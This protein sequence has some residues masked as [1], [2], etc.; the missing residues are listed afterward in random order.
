MNT[1]TKSR[2][3]LM[4]LMAM[5]L[6]LSCWLVVPS[7]VQEVGRR[8]QNTAFAGIRLFPDWRF[9]FQVLGL[10]WHPELTREL[11]ISNHAQADIC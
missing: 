9:L 10:I 8:W 7:P 4:I 11:G 1:A 3:A 6:T 5:G 2:I